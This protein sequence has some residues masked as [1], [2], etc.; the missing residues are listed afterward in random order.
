MSLKT[1]REKVSREATKG[2]LKRE[3][4]RGKEQRSE[5]Q[6][7]EDRRGDRAED[8]NRYLL[9]ERGREKKSKSRDLNK[10]S[11]KTEGEKVS[12][13]PTQGSL[14]RGEERKRARPEI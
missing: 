8:L 9:K 5:E 1:D 11:L 10:R 14:K 3:G 6:V 2:S 13:E 4:K 12:R 7:S